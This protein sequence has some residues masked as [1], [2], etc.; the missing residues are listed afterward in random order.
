MPLSKFGTQ[1][2]REFLQK[3]FVCFYFQ[4]DHQKYTNKYLN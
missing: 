1:A 3:S 2:A 4:E